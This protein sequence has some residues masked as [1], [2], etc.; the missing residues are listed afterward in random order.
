MPVAATARVVADQPA[1]APLSG[2]PIEVRGKFFFAGERKYFVKGV[3]YG[4][5]ADA[6]HGTQFPERAMV[7]RDFALMAEMGANTLPVF[8]VPPVWL[9]DIAAATGRTVLVGSPSS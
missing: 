4:P 8:T 2:A 5:F 1:R 7:E 9:L 6:S 3:T